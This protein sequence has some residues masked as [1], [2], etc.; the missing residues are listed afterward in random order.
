MRGGGS[1]QQPI[2]PTFPENC[3]KSKEFGRR[4]GGGVCNLFYNKILLLCCCIFV[5]DTYV[6]VPLSLGV[7]DPYGSFILRLLSINVNI[8]IS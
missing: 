6:T 8:T 2:L 3:M 5:F 4:K 1:H 7:N